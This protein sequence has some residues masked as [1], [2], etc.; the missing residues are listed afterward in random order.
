MNTHPKSTS[1]QLPQPKLSRIDQL[2]PAPRSAR[3]HSSK[4]LRQIA[5]SIRAFGFTNPV[6]VDAAG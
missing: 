6:L 2:R 5:E 3:T 4:Q 1:L